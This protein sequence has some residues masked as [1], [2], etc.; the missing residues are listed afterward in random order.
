M[1]AHQP[2]YEKQFKKF[3]VVREQRYSIPRKNLDACCTFLYVDNILKLLHDDK[4]EFYGRQNGQDLSDTTWYSGYIK[5]VIRH[6]IN[7]LEFF[8]TRFVDNSTLTQQLDFYFGRIDAGQQ[9]GYHFENFN[10]AT[11]ANFPPHT[12]HG[13]SVLNMPVTMVFSVLTLRRL[14]IN[15][16]SG[17]SIRI[18]FTKLI[19]FIQHTR[20]LNRILFDCVIWTNYLLKIIQEAIQ[21][22][23]RLGGAVCDS[24]EAQFCNSGCVIFD[25]L[26][27]WRDDVCWRRSMYNTGN[28]IETEIELIDCLAILFVK[29]KNSI[30]HAPVGYVQTNCK[31]KSRLYCGT[32]LM[33]YKAG[34]LPFLI[35]FISAAETHKDTRLAESLRETRLIEYL[36]THG[37]KYFEVKKFLTG[38]S[39]HEAQKKGTHW[40]NTFVKCCEVEVYRL[41]MKAKEMFDALAGAIRLDYDTLGLIVEFCTAVPKNA[42]K[43]TKTQQ[44]IT[45]R[46]QKLKP[47]D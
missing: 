1:T 16:Q 28:A 46:Q 39:T 22:F 43:K 24:Y 13:R 47:V 17:K 42:Y 3:L 27:L 37:C 9:L 35:E 6:E 21:H 23:E 4:F 34:Y 29:W 45:W 18:Q 30:K 26:N 15:L 7:R 31:C 40:H 41:K 5:R 11:L 36:I 38:N 12:E 2:Y 14:L 33:W 20:E 19:T 25:Q 32:A 8:T 44:Q 10:Y